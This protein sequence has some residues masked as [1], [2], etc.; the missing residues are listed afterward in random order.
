VFLRYTIAK[1]VP[2]SDIDDWAEKHGTR[3]GTRKKGSDYGDLG[4]WGKRTKTSLPEGKH[5]QDF[6]GFT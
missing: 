4:M 1:S 6:H 5:L 3:N 2:C